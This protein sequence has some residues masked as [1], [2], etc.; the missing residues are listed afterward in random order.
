MEA[1]GFDTDA[2]D[3]DALHLL[4]SVMAEIAQRLP[5]REQRP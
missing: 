5:L 2:L 1:A 3:P 4:V